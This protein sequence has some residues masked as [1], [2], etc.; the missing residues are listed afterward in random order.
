[1]DVLQRAAGARPA[2]YRYRLTDA[3]LQF[4]LNCLSQGEYVESKRLRA[5]L[6]ELELTA[7]R[8]TAK[9]VDLLE[10]RIAAD[11]GVAF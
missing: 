6:A 5:A 7:V 4:H 10:G 2:P 8:A 11:P 9:A 3:E 1:M